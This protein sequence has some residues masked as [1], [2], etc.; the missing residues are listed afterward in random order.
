[1]ML[2]VV[3]TTYN[4]P[5]A[6]AAVL[7]GFEA[8]H[9]RGFELLVADDGSGPE[10]AAVVE[11]FRRRGR[12]TVRH[13]WQEDQGFRAAAARNRALAATT[14]PYVVF[15]DGDCV[16]AR[17]FVATHRRL[18]EPGWFLAGN[19]LLLGE[20]LTR[21][22]L[23]EGIE[24]AHWGAGDWLAARRRGEVNRLAPLLRLPDTALRK[25][26]ARRWQGVKTCNFSAWRAD[27]VAVN[28]FDER[29]N[30]WGLEDSDLVVRLLR[31]GIGH[32]SARCA[33][34]VF[35]LWHPEHDR[36]GLEANR[37]RLQAVLA[38]AETRAQ[39]GMDQYAGGTSG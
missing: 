22:V 5:D 11:R 35:H 29:Y 27:L 21:R 14:C 20:L 18:A 32:K 36:S 23:A 4:R 37:A 34:P 7:A 16:P 12:C 17:D 6:L 3:V 30:G 39:L 2:A 24:L 15:T 33:A 1:M 8:Q 25:L 9:E 28:G 38:A 10:T 31:L 19:R 13:V 26:R